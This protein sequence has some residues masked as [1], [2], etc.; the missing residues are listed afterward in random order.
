MKLFL[1]LMT[2]N[3]ILSGW[4]A[5]VTL[6]SIPISLCQWLRSLLLMDLWWYKSNIISIRIQDVEVSKKVDHKWLNRFNLFAETLLAY[7]EINNHD[8][9]FN[10][11][12]QIFNH[13]TLTELSKVR[14][15]VRSALLGLLRSQSCFRKKDADVNLYWG[16]IIH[17]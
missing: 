7:I 9:F 13:P 2:R 10:S 1:H 5:Y 17:P 11:L 12:W 8:A 4:P 6:V 15:K 3:Y 16:R 14:D